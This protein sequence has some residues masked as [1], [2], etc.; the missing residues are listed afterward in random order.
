MDNSYRFFKN[1]ACKYFPCHKGLK[2]FNCLFCF[3]PF[4]LREDCPGNPKFWN[5]EGTI[6]KDCSDCAFPHYPEHYDTMMAG[7]GRATRRARSQ[8]RSGRQ[9][10]LFR[11]SIRRRK[12]ESGEADSH[13]FL[14]GI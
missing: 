2:E 10:C 5:K 13:G 1:E 11:K 6:I 8:R 7:S 9:Q 3:C 12:H 4:Y 14:R